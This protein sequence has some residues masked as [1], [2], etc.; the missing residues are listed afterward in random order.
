MNALVLLLTLT[1][2]IVLRSGE[3]IAAEGAVREEKGVVIFR[4]NGVFYS[5]PAEEVER[6][7]KQQTPD[8]SQTKVRRLAVSEEERRR[9]LAALEK[10]HSGVAPKPLPLPKE[11]PP[12]PSREEAAEQRR[13]ENDW[14][15]EARAHEESVRRANEELAL[16]ESRADELRSQIHGFV[17]LGYRPRQFT[18]QTTQL[19]RVLAQIPYAELEVTR[20]VRAYDQFREDARRQGVMPGWLR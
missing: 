11:I 5:M 6:I 18:Y 1:S 15:R 9:L 19:E 3:R 16:L 8:G 4:S 2:T 13:E 20:A 14:R 7:E 10:N 12:P 17:S